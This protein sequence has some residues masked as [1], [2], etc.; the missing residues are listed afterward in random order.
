MKVNCIICGK[1]F[2]AGHPPRLFCSVGCEVDASEGRTEWREEEDSA[3]P[4]E[5]RLPHAWMRE[6]EAFTRPCPLCGAK[7]G[8]SCAGGG[9]HV[10][11]LGDKRWKVVDP[12]RP[13]TLRVV[14]E[15]E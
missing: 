11:R 15:D 8:W 5:E 6:E 2:S 14:E 10:A 12:P 7:K 13:P 9:L 4:I 3:V 1:K